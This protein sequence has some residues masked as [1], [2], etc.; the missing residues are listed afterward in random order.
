M[1]F[2]DVFNYNDYDRVVR[3]LLEKNI[4]IIARDKVRMEVVADISPEIEEQIYALPFDEFASIGA[5]S[6]NVTEE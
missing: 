2:I 6:V 1:R 3:F 5:R 4:P